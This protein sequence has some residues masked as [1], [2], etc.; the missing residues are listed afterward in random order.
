MISRKRLFV[1]FKK[2][3]SMV[4]ALVMM[5]SVCAVSGISLSVSAATKAGQN[6]AIF[7]QGQYIYFNCKN[8]TNWKDS[9]AVTKCLMYNQWPDNSQPVDSIDMQQMSNDNNLYRCFMLAND[10]KY[11]KIQR[12][13]QSGEYWGEL[14]NNGSSVFSVDSNDRNNNPAPTDGNSNCL[15]VSNSSFS[16]ASWGTV[17]DP[18]N[19]I[20]KGT[21]V[22]KQA[23]DSSTMKA[24]NLN[25]VKGTFYDYYNNDEMRNGWLKLDGSERSYKDRE[26]FTFFNNAVANYARSNSSWER[27]LYFGDF[28]RSNNNYWKDGY[29]GAGVSNFYK[30]VSRA[31][32]AAATSAG[33]EGAVAGLVD[34]KL[35]NGNITSGSVALP[36]FS[37][38]FLSQ[39]Y[40]AVVKSN[41]PFREEIRNNDTYYVYNSTGGRDNFYF[42]DLTGTPVANYYENQNSI[43]DAASGF[44]NPSNGKGLFPFDKPNTDALDF[45]F[46]IKLEIPFT[47]PANGKTLNGNDV[48]FNFWGDDD[49]WVFIDD[50]L[51]LDMGGAH[52][53]ATG[54]LNFTKKTATANKLDTTFGGSLQSTLD[55]KWGAAHTMKVFYMERGM[56]ESNMRIDYNFDPV[57]NLLTTSKTVDTQNLNEGL[58]T[59]LLNNS[60]FEIQNKDI[61]AGTNLANRDYTIGSQT[62][63]SSSTGTYE[64]KHGQTVSFSGIVDSLLDKPEKVGDKLSVT[65]NKTGNLKYTTSYVVKDMANEAVISTGNNATATFD[66]INSATKNPRDYAYYDVA[67]TNKPV[68]SKLN[69]SKTAYDKDGTTQISDT[70]FEFRVGV[71]LD[72]GTN[73]KYY[74][75]VYTS[76]GSRKTASGGSFTLR[77]GQN[78]VFE[79]IPVGAT[80]VVT[81][82]GNKDYTIESP[83]SGKVTGTMT[84]AGGTA[85]FVNK[86]INKDPATVTLG[87]TKKL[88]NKTPNV[89]DFE[90]SLKEIT[91]SGS[92]VQEF[93][94][95]KNNGGRVIFAPIKYEYE[96]EPTQPTTVPTQPT[97]QPTTAPP[98]PTTQPTTAPPITNNSTVYVKTADGKAPTIYAW[99]SSGNLAGGW[100]GTKATQKSGDY[101]YVELNTT[102]TYN[103]IISNDSGSQ[104]SDIENL[105]KNTYIVYNSTSIND[106]AMQTG[107]SG[108]PSPTPAVEN[109]RVYVKTSDGV[110][111][112]IY[113]WNSSGAL[114]GGWP[115]SLPTQKS[116]DY[117]YVDLNTTGAYNVVVSK[118]G[119]ENV[120]TKDLENL[121]KDTYITITNS[122]DFWNNTTFETGKA[123]ASYSLRSN[124]RNMVSSVGAKT[125]EY[126]YYEIAEKAGSNAA[127]TYDGSK[128]YAAVQ[129]NYQTTP[130]TAEAK[131]YKTLADAV[132]GKNEIQESQVEFNNYHKG[133]VTVIKE[134]QGKVKL[135]GAEFT[136]YKVNSDGDTK[137]TDVVDKLTTGSNGEVKF[138]DLDIFKDKNSSTSPQWYAIKE[139]KAPNGYNVN[140]TVT[141]FTLPVADDAGNQHYDITYTYTDGA[142]IMPNTSGNGTAFWFI[143]GT[144]IIGTGAMLSFAYF[145]YNNAQRKK[146]RARCCAK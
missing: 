75:L 112:K 12:Y 33:F 45:G 100:P 68:V 32:N 39:G 9:G 136:L 97:T 40:G 63:K 74:D 130:I 17:T 92:L 5:L 102:G 43:W 120:K 81:E 80:Y 54:S 10:V 70:D 107:Q 131:Y 7:G 31:N 59:A 62:G 29:Q 49:L 64:I 36:Y 3:F 116:G 118:N 24:D 8:A 48:V 46:G 114:A 51:V 79:G 134:S 135:K 19:T 50:V 60:K 119:N 93:A 28:N 21:F 57:E 55:V 99:N 73:Y 14:T 141:Y 38:S 37:E 87:A 109:S 124:A 143:L 127:Y 61:T 76:N 91:S 85:D 83:A 18:D 78:A 26:P 108:A 138:K 140:N 4:L 23:T 15:Y 52:K 144:G 98:Q 105:S 111:P 146:R 145:M 30:Y 96:E 95:V 20:T 16:S 94:S 44:G 82:S 69:V 56:A 101:W 86:K 117:W 132:S 35:T 125:I 42:T 11:V 139:T 115:G 128:F 22:S 133:S 137:L 123:R 34:N 1:C 88:D 121:S 84:E 110:A 25:L 2:S 142:V 72:G 65:E 67:F 77:G 47:I 113:A 6:G 106:Y 103:V 89:N 71:D 53:M 122:S 58:K 66:F 90:F 126:H 41:F 13:S 27:P 129:V 104:T